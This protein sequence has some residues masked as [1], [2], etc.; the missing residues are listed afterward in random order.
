MPINDDDKF[1]EAMAF[2]ASGAPNEEWRP[3][4]DRYKD[5]KRLCYSWELRAWCLLTEDGKLLTLD[6]LL[7]R[8]YPQ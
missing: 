2:F 6:S 1:D 7:E 5:E 8:G 3:E 4:Y